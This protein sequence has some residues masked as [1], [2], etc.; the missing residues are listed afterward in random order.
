VLLDGRTI[1]SGDVLE[2]DVCIVG[3]GPAGLVLAGELVAA[4]RGVTVVEAGGHNEE[5]RGRVLQESVRS[6][7]LRYPTATTRRCSVEGSASTWFVPAP[8]GG[9]TLRLREFDPLD[10][11]ARPWLDLPGWPVDTQQLRPF[12]QRAR[13][14]FGIPPMAEGRWGT[15]DATLLSSPLVPTGSDIEVKPFDFGSAQLF[16]EAHCRRVTRDPEVPVVYNSPVDELRCRPDGGS[17]FEAVC[18][19]TDDRSFTISARTFVLAAGG[20]ENARLL[21]ASRSRGPQ[22]LGNDHD[23]VGRHFMEHPRFSAALVAVGAASPLRDPAVHDIHDHQGRPVQRKY[24]L[25]AEAACRH[26]AANHQ[27]FFRHATLNSSVLGQLDGV[28]V[29]DRRVG[30]HRLKRI[31]RTGTLPGDRSDLL[32]QLG[33]SA[34]YPLKWLE[35]HGRHWAGRAVP[36]RFRH[37]PLLTLEVMMEQLPNPQ[38]RIRLSRSGGTGPIPT[39]DLEWRLRPEEWQDVHASTERLA[40]ALRRHGDAEVLNLVPADGSPPSRLIKAD[41]HMGTT[42]MDP[43][44]RLG[45][46]DV[47]GRVHGLHNLY[48]VGSSNFPT[49]GGAN[50]TL[51]IVAFTLRLADL[52]RRQNDA[53]V[54]VR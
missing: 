48:V 18:H 44:P 31:V 20:I 22:G 34:S 15:W 45:V 5:A 51:T 29:S 3:A 33:Q 6:T 17:I 39:A 9:D 27:F 36:T 37:E 21:L 28:N 7:G 2:T 19:P 26:R 4:G 25:H 35:L 50:P 30:L 52:L 10:L 38:S 41:H 24:A 46:V 13:A 43:D 8:H 23:L 54:R 32:R 11:Q 12:Y 49:A 14:L 47:H 16:L 53:D 42:R 1:P 40:E